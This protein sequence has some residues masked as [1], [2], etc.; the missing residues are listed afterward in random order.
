MKYIKNKVHNVPFTR[1]ITFKVGII[2]IILRGCVRSI[3]S[4]LV[5]PST[6]QFGLV[7][8]SFFFNVFGV[9]I[10]FIINEFVFFFLY[11]IINIINISEFSMQQCKPD[12]MPYF[13]VSG[14]DCHCVFNYHVSKP[15]WRTSWKP[16]FMRIKVGFEKDVIVCFVVFSLI[17]AQITLNFI[18]MLPVQC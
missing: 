2:N 15:M 4:Y 17:T 18:N 11:I 1:K 3:F 14:L 7:F 9:W 16:Q 12:H 10:Q 13:A 6:L 5:H 8:S